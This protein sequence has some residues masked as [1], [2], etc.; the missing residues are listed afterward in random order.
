MII[1]PTVGRKIWYSPSTLFDDP[2]KIGEQPFDATIVY[3][4]D[5]KLVNL[6]VTDHN[7]NT[8][9]RGNVTLLQE[10]DAPNP[11]GGHCYWMPYQKGQAAK[12]DELESIAATAR[13]A[14]AAGPEAEY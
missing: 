12:T 10:G 5:D 7:G 8:F 3:V 9:A 14:R 1:K 13:A 4:W 2:P 6:R 11:E